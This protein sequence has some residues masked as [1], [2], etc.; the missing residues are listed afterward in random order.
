MRIARFHFIFFLFTGELPWKDAVFSQY[1]R[2]SDHTQID[3]DMCYI[4]DM[5]IMGYAMRTKHYRYIEWVSFNHTTYFADF[6]QVSSVEEEY[7][8]ICVVK[9]LEK[10]CK[11]KANS[12]LGHLNHLIFIAAFQVLMAVF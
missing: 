11:L 3:S 4:V 5:K 2:P 8:S 1:P 6:N 7:S 9:F 12:C 10:C